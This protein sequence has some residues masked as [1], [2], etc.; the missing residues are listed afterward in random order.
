LDTDKI[1]SYTADGPR[2][3]SKRGF[4]L[5]AAYYASTS[6]DLRPVFPRWVPFGCGAASLV[7]LIFLFAGGAFLS[8]GGIGKVLDFMFAQMEIELTSAYGKDVPAPQK[9]EL[10]AAIDELRAN[11]RAD[12]VKLPAIEPLL[13]S[14]R[15][16]TSDKTL[17]PDEVSRLV[18]EIH[19]IDHP[20]TGSV[21]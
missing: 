1:E 5:P 11:I 6:S 17:T 19:E 7:L 20:P 18:R 16:A 9:M 4:R 13:Q 8:S 2:E 12:R 15:E 10:S 3:P 14:M 21:K